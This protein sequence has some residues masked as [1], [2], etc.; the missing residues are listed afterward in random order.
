M[1]KKKVLRNVTTC[2]KILSGCRDGRLKTNQKH[3]QYFSGGAEKEIASR[4]A[5]SSLR[6]VLW[7]T[8][9]SC[10]DVCVFVVTVKTDYYNPGPNAA[11]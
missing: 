4:N 5:A 3:V 7:N 9:F 1:L 2:D 6:G 10:Y 8:I 11:G